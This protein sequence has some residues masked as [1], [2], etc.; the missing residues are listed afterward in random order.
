MERP[1]ITITRDPDTGAI[2]ITPRDGYVLTD[3]RGEPDLN[4][5]VMHVQYG[6]TWPDG[7]NWNITATA[8]PRAKVARS[9]REA[10]DTA[11]RL[12]RLLDQTPEDT[13]A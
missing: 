8:K 6:H 3:E 2:I 12:T 13:T 4:T 5:G 10:Q 1:P 11:D 7:T 9:A